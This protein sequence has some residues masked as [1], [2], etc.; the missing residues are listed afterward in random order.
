MGRRLC[1][2]GIEDV[3]PNESLFRERISQDLEA[4]E[5]DDFVKVL[6]ELSDCV[7]RKGNQLGRC[8]VAEHEIQ[9]SENARPI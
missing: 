3:G 9:L 4:E 5:K 6:R 8:K 1:S 2:L 7:T